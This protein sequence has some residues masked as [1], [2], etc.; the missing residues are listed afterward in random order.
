MI[1]RFVVF[2]CHGNIDF[3][4]ITIV[5]NFSVKP[6]SGENFMSI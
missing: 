4:K 6:V 3:C 1:A 2:C 5:I